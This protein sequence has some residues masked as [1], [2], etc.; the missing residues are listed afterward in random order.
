MQK[1]T[2]KEEEMSLVVTSKAVT[3]RFGKIVR[4]HSVDHTLVIDAI[5][6][7]ATFFT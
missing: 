7:R 1:L 4:M 3:A 5:V 2:N 6:D